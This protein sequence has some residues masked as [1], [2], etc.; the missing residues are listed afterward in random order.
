MKNHDRSEAPKEEPKKRGVGVFR[1]LITTIIALII[2]IIYGFF[3]SGQLKAE[4]I[5][6]GSME[7]TIQIGDR[8]IMSSVFQGE[9]KRGDVVIFEPEEANELPMIKRV[10]GVSGDLIHVLN[11]KVYVNPPT[12]KLPIDAGFFEPV[13]LKYI[14]K[15][16]ENHFYVL[17]D[18]RL[19]SYDSFFFG[20]IHKDRIIG[21]ALYIYYPY[22]HM[23]NLG[24]E[25]EVEGVMK[26]YTLE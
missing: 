8:V 26:Q 4:E 12:E 21:K 17:G 23:K 6:S 7:P 15:V 19:S 13:A 2:A 11:N 20:P 16:P 24:N 22:K 9:P 1:L 18:N 10:V 25:A 3:A 14:L 5:I